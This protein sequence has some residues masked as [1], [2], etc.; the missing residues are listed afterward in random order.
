MNLYLFVVGGNDIAIVSGYDLAEAYPIVQR[1]NPN[2]PIIF[3]KKIGYNELN[4]KVH[5]RYD[6]APVAGIGKEE[7]KEEN[8]QNTVNFL[9]AVRDKY[10]AKHI[11]TIIKEVEYGTGAGEG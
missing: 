10:G 11:S 4:E 9:K 1:E 2:R 5:G 3:S 6:D 8:I 7:R